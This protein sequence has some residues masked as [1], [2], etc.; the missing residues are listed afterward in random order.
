MAAPF[1]MKSGIDSSVMEAISSYT[2]CATVSNDDAGM[3]KYI[4]VTATVPSAK[5]MGMPENITKSVAAPYDRP[6]AS[7]LML[8]LSELRRRSGARQIEG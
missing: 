3:K 7:S 2:F 4:K 1:M 5:A 6:I 8:Q